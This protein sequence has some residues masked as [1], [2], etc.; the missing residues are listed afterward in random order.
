MCV[1]RKAPLKPPLGPFLKKGGGFKTPHGIGFLRTPPPPW[2][3][4]YA[5][6]RTRSKRR[7][8]RGRARVTARPLGGG[9]GQGGGKWG[10]GGRRGGGMGCR[11]GVRGTW[12]RPSPPPSRLFTGVYSG[13]GPRPPH[14]VNCCNFSQKWRNFCKKKCKVKKRT[15]SLSSST[16]Y[17]NSKHCNV[18]F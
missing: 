6:R 5:G 4:T 15:V 12:W 2:G 10:G 3:T 8:E 18:V 16:R 17:K 13:F 9:G 7:E 14:G 11:R 1:R